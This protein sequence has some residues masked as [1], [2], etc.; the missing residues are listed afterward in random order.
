[1]WGNMSEVV[2]PSKQ[3]KLFALKNALKFVYV[4]SGDHYKISPDAAW[5]TDKLIRMGTTLQIFKIFRHGDG[6]I[7]IFASFD[8]ET[9][10]YDVSSLFDAISPLQAKPYYLQEID[11]SS[12][13]APRPQS[14]YDPNTLCGMPIK[15]IPENKNLSY[16]KSV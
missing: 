8:G 2:L 12:P 11:R 7:Q 1:M 3:N 14:I 16:S 15:S 6:H 10:L 9:K 4:K 5:T 13:L